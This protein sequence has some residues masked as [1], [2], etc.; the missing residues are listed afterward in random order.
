MCS[1]GE[2]IKLIHRNHIHIAELIQINLNKPLRP[3]RAKL[4]GRVYDFALVSLVF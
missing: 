1:P 3:I 4:Q 2:K